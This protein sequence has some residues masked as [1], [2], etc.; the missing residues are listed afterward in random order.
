M[1]QA[2]KN[3]IILMCITLG[4]II[5]WV[6]VE[7]AR[8]YSIIALANDSS[9]SIERGN[10]DAEDDFEYEHVHFKR[11]Y[12]G[13]DWEVPGVS[14]KQLNGIFKSHDPRSVWRCGYGHYNYM[15][16]LALNLTKYEHNEKY[17]VAYNLRLSALLFEKYKSSNKLL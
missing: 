1:N 11:F 7:M 6:M 13:R 10:K 15:Q 5:S 2:I 4:L 8:A 12:S 3:T 14:E 16:D 17:V 9:A